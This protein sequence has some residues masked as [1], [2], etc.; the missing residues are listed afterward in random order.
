MKM[1]SRKPRRFDEGGEV[2]DDEPFYAADADDEAVGEPISARPAAP[3]KAKPAAK[4]TRKPAAK[5]APKAEAKPARKYESPLTRLDRTRRE[6]RQ[7]ART[8]AQANSR[9]VPTRD[10]MFAR[11]PTFM[12]LRGQGMAKGGSVSA[13]R[14]ADGAAQ[15]GK[16]RGRVI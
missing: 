9:N 5:P 6:E 11:N 3:A 14:R 12:S 13:S 16:T 10:E 8:V 2:D 1:S 4:R 7:A 15:R